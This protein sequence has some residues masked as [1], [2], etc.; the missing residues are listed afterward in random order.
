MSRYLI[1]ASTLL[2]LA[3]ATSVLAQERPGVEVPTIAAN[4]AD[5]STID[6]VIK[7]FYDVIS[8]PAGQAR[9]W[10]RDRT[11]YIPGVR[12]VSMSVENG[13]PQASIMTHQEFV[14]RTDRGLVTNGFFESEIHRVTRKFGNTT[15]VFST[16][17]MKD[18]AGRSIGRGVNSIQLFWDGDRWWISG[19]AWDDERPENPIPS[20]LL[21]N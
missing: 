11:L 7:T 10:A 18:G 5:V 2:G 19:V 4:P 21:S 15:H 3:T 8:G 9:Q 16:Y 13:R 20:E 17:E 6:A 12:F 14:D 1:A